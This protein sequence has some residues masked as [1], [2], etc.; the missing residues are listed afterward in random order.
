MSKVK[1]RTNQPVY[2]V[3]KVAEQVVQADKD[4]L[5]QIVYDEENNRV[6]FPPYIVPLK[7]FDGD[8]T[9]YLYFDYTNTSLVDRN[10][11]ELSDYVVDFING[12]QIIIVCPQGSMCDILELVYINANGIDNIDTTL[13]FNSFYIFNPVTSA[14]TKLYKHEL[15]FNNGMQ[16]NVISWRASKYTLNDLIDGIYMGYD[17]ITIVYWDND[18]IL[19]NLQ[20]NIEDTE[21]AYSNYALVETTISS[22]TSV[23]D[24][25]T[26]L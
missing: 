2:G 22:I 4:I 1:T 16:I 3:K 15:R 20:Y 8:Y 14:G 25:V 26:E 19:Y 6:I 9:K 7:V 18:V 11:E 12:N 23:A 10:N 13:N 5:S 21:L 24:T 17:A